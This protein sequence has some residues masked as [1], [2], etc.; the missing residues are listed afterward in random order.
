M[1]AG[2]AASTPRS[3]RALTWIRIVIGVDC[4]LRAFEGWRLIGNVLAPSSLRLPYIA[5]ATPIPEELLPW[6]VAAW[7]GLAAAFAFGWRPRL[8]GPLLSA[9]MFYVL[10]FDQQTYSNHLYLLASVALLVGLGNGGHADPDGQVPSWPVTLVK[11][12]LTVLY[13]FST[14]SKINASYL[15]GIVMYVN[16]RPGIKTLIGTDPPVPALMV[17]VA[18]VSLLIEGFLAVALWSPRRRAR[19]ASI[20]IVFH[21]GLIAT[22]GGAVTVQVSI[23]AIATLA[24]YLAFFDHSPRKLTL[25]YDDGCGFCTRIVERLCAA[26]RGRLIT[27]VGLSDR[28]AFRHDLSR[29]D[30]DSSVVVIDDETGTAFTRARAFA[31]VARTLPGAYQ[32]LRLAALPGF[33]RVSD[34]L[35][36][37]V[38]RRRHRISAWLGLNACEIRVKS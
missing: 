13:F 19:A 21:A 14:I 27:A 7:A 34:A 38:A 36:D 4:F 35:Y 24:L 37:A 6:F 33:V 3:G 5:W 8:T 10:L 28:A 9:L 11:I 25:Y 20:G 16:L 15:T 30:L 31:A 32:P 17:V 18:V 26:D 29:F 1:K 2:A 22:I 23:F 12:Q